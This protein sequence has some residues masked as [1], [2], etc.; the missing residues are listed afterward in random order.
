MTHSRAW[1]T[2]V[3]PEYRW[4]YPTLDPDTFYSVRESRS[5]LSE[6][7]WLWLDADPYAVQVF[8]D[9]LEPLVSVPH[10]AVVAASDGVLRVARIRP[11]HVARFADVPSD[12]WVVARCLAER[13][14]HQATKEVSRRRRRR[15]P[16]AYVEFR[17]EDVR[18]RIS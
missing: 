1:F 12:A 7:G 4:P 16:D 10:S 8:G 5:P 2:R 3:R 13:H 14:A 17:T 9:H 15:L 18:L 6:P 11:E